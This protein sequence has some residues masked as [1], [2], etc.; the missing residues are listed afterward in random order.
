M[1]NIVKCVDLKSFEIGKQPYLNIQA[2][3]EP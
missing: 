1:E 3:K 2:D